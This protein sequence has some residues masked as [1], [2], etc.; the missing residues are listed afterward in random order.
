MKNKFYF[1]L[2][3]DRSSNNIYNSHKNLINQFSKKLKNF[4]LLNYYYLN[5][6]KEK[7]KPEKKKQKN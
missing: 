2:Y 4:Y 1:L 3:C 7:F 6:P 5:F